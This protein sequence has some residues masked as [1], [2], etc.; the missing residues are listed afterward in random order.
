MTIDLDK[1]SKR[2]ND[3]EAARAYLESLRWPHGVVCPHCGQKGAYRLEARPGSKRPGRKGLWKC[4]DPDCGSQFTVTVGTIFED[5]HIPLSKW[6]LA[7]HLLS[8]SKKGMS[9]HQLHRMLDVTYRSAWFM[10]HRIRYAMV[11][12]PYTKLLKGTVEVDETYVGGKEPRHKGVQGRR[13]PNKQA[14]VS[15]VQREGESRS[16]Q[17]KRLT[18]DALR[19]A[20]REH[21]EP[22]STV[23]TDGYRGYLGVE[24]D[25]R[26]HETVNH[27]TGEYVRGNVHTNT[28]EGYFAILKRGIIGTYHHISPQHL[29]RYL[30]EFDFRYSH[31]YIKDGDRTQQA[32]K[33]AEGKRL[34]YRDTKAHIVVKAQ[35]QA[36]E[37]KDHRPD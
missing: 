15:L 6:L 27:V 34:T 5:S 20:I 14:V 35:G 28:V 10:A 37:D 22:Q 3:D 21:I 32:L 23:Y 16:F 31:R 7:F 4:K 36:R 12:P 19:S 9:A 18:G 11:Q 26:K 25:V 30:H 1:I 17:M 33:M 8:A 24:Y 29:Q 13:Q 2:F